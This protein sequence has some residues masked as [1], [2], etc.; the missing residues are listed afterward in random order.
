MIERDIPGHGPGRV[1]E[2]ADSAPARPHSD[3]RD[4][5]AAP[6]STKTLAWFCSSE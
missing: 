1:L 2:D 6:T 5:L 4:L 3:T